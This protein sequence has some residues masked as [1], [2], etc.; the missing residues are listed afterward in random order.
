[1]LNNVAKAQQSLRLLRFGLALNDR[2]VV[3]LV[4][5]SPCLSRLLALFGR[6]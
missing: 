4:R 2:F 5:G 3:V 1:M 6:H